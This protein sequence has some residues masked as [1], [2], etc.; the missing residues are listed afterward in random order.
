[1]DAWYPQLIDHA[2][3]AWYDSGRYEAIYQ[4]RALNK[5]WCDIIRRRIKRYLANHAM[6]ERLIHI[7]DYQSII[8][9]GL[10]KLA[11]KLILS[12]RLVGNRM[13]AQFVVKFGIQRGVHRAGIKRL[14][15]EQLARIS[16]HREP[17][18]EYVNEKYTRLGLYDMLYN[19]GILPFHDMYF[20]IIVLS[21]WIAGR[22]FV[23][24][25]TVIEAM[26]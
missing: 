9:A 8:N 4:C 1:M 6:I 23:P 3:V 16:K 5:L 2:I 18:L 24:S 7:A 17:I 12:Y 19:H 26:Y 14:C 15:D 22:I 21:M 10:A 25:A 13:I 11:S 20:R